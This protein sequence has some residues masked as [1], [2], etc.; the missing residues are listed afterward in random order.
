MV[1]STLDPASKTAIH[2]SPRSDPLILTTEDLLVD[3][4]P[5][6][7]LFLPVGGRV[8]M[9]KF[10]KEGEDSTLVTEDLSDVDV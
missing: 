3:E 9:L 8:S 4:E 7:L 1:S 5:G 6:L 10:G 2:T